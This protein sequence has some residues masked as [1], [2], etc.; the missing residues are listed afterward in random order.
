MQVVFKV[1]E[2]LAAQQLQYEVIVGAYLRM[3][4]PRPLS[5]EA[6]PMLIPA[7]LAQLLCWDA[8]N[9]PHQIFLYANEA[10]KLG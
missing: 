7:V 6:L 10:K 5:L 3:E 1:R 9:T 2:D 4:Q 8:V